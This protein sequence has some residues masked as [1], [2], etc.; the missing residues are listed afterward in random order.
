MNVRH[1]TTDPAMGACTLIPTAPLVSSLCYYKGI[2]VYKNARMV[3]LKKFLKKKMWLSAVLSV[4]GLASS[5][6]L[7]LPVKNAKSP[8]YLMLKLITAVLLKKR[9]FRTARLKD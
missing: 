9:H 6:A 4:Y 8:T 3:T 7:Q 2:S 5:A 1:V